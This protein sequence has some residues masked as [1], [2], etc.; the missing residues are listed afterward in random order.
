MFPYRFCLA[1]L[2]A[3]LI[4]GPAAALT[5][6]PD[7]STPCGSHTEGGLTLYCYVTQDTTSSFGL[8]IRSTGALP[9][10]DTFSDFSYHGDWFAEIYV[11]VYGHDDTSL[12]EFHVIGTGLHFNPPHGEGSSPIFGFA[13]DYVGPGGAIAS[14]ADRL[15]HGE[16]FD[17]WKAND[18]VA[19]FGFSFNINASHTPEPGTWSLM[20]LGLG[21]AG[22]ALRRRRSPRGLG[23]VGAR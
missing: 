18:R 17:V 20:I 11:F 3:C 8:H 23:A 22:G 10:T 13:L 1:L 15:Q 4:C 19:P 12:D 14:A 7:G 9:T 5:A 2:A 16:H 21:L 6:I